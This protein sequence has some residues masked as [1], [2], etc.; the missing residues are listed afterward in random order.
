MILLL[1]GMKHCGKSTIGRALGHRWHVQ[2]H[3]V[4]DLTCAIHAAETGQEMTFRQIYAQLGG[5]YFRRC[6]G[7]AVESIF[8][9]CLDQDPWTILAL[10]GGTA[11][12]PAAA[13]RLADAQ[14]KA[15]LHVEPDE[16]LRRI[17]RTGLPAFLD[18]DDVNGS[19]RRLYR[20][21]EPAYQALADVTVELTDLDVEASIDAAATAIAD[22]CRAAGLPDPAAGQ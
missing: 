2:F 8:R 15:Y 5:E 7:A 21:R 20:R 9:R 17:E 14:A 19:F 6:E 18:P 10:G 1:L 4:D 3:D 16:L 12:N 22:H 11:E 13:D